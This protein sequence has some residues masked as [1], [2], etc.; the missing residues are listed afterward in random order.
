MSIT[1]TLP[2]RTQV[3]VVY[4]TTINDDGSASCTCAAGAHGRSCWHIALMRQTLAAYD[5]IEAEY[6]AAYPYL[7]TARSA[8]ARLVKRMPSIE[9]AREYAAATHRTGKLQVANVSG[10]CVITRI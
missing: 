4:Q 3:N 7:L 9:A 5:A 8:S 10:P 6:D 2:S 1:A